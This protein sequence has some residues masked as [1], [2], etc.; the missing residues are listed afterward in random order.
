M[1]GGGGGCEGRVAAGE[2]VIYLLS[3]AIRLA[4]L[5]VVHK[6][7]LQT[8]QRQ[9]SIFTNRMSQ[10]EMSTLHIHNQDDRKRNGQ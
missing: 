10:K 3:D 6:V 5:Q 2:R 8:E 4:A 1:R 7:H 9:L